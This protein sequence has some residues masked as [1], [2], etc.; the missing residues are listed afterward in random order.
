MQSAAKSKE[1]RL[2]YTQELTTK[3]EA[4]QAGAQTASSL[5]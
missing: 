4:L 2:A 3:M 1:R 5:L